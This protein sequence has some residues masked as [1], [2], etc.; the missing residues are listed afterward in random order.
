MQKFRKKRTLN[1]VS[2][3]IPDVVE[4]EVDHEQ[5]SLDYLLELITTL[6]ERY[7][8]VFN[9]YVLDEYSHKE[10]AAMLNISVGTSKSNLSRA[11]VILRNKMEYHQKYN[12]KATNETS[13]ETSFY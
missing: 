7:R 10:I 11:R 9:L 1:I 6:P 4:V 12:K 13:I 3:E 8:M 5:V 2:D